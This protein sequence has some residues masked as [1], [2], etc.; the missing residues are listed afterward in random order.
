MRR[1]IA[2]GSSSRASSP[3]ACSDRSLRKWPHVGLCTSRATAPGPSY[4]NIQRLGI[5]LLQRRSVGLFHRHRE[6]LR[7]GRVEITDIQIALREGNFDAFGLE[8]V[9]DVGVQIVR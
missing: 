7:V 2:T 1:T 9:V 3:S 8:G 5:L 4:Q 6:R